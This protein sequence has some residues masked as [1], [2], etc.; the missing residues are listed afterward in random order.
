MEDSR[1]AEYAACQ[2]LYK[3]TRVQEYK[4]KTKPSQA[5]K[6]QKRYFPR[7]SRI[8]SSK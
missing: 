7:S 2:L 5:Q 4:T 1:V 6:T 3:S 8:R